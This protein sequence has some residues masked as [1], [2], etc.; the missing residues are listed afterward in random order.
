MDTGDGGGFWAR[1]LAND[2]KFGGTAETVFSVAIAK[3]ESVI[4]DEFF[5]LREFCV[6]GGWGSRPISDLLVQVARNRC[7]SWQAVKFPQL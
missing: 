7:N 1:I 6:T 3:I 2:K 4:C 5:R